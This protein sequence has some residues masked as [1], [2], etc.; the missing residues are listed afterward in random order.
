MEVSLEVSLCLPTWVLD[1][2]DGDAVVGFAGTQ[3][4]HHVLDPPQLTF[5][6][7]PLLLQFDTL[8]IDFTPV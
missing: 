4:R 3:S 1:R 6:L 8:L 7:T 2:V 5:H